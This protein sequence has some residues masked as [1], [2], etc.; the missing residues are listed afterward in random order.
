MFRIGKL[1][2]KE[3]ICALMMQVWL[4]TYAKQGIKRAI[5]HY[6]FTEFNEAKIV[7]GIK[8]TN[9][10]YFVYEIN[11]HLVGVATV[12]LSAKHPI[13]QE[14]FPEIS[15]LYIQEYFTSKGIGSK[16]L[17]NLIEHCR[18]KEYSKVWLTVNSKNQ[19]AIEFYKSHA[20]KKHGVT[21]FKLEEERHEN[22]I[23]CKSIV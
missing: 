23:L 19:R 7:A 17:N 5:S 4:H 9:E 20:F 1:E 18:E 2:D 11:G 6:V 16:L 3:N 14:E 10:K 12:N 15:R 21:H 8:S 13:T 22:L